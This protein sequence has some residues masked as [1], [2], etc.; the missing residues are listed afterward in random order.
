MAVL[1]IRNNILSAQPVVTHLNPVIEKL[2]QGKHVFGVSTTDLSIANAHALARAD[3]DYVRVEMEHAPMDFGALH[4]FLIGMIDK[5][6]ILKKGNAQLNAAPFIRIAPYGR[7]QAD[8][9][10][11]QALDLGI[12]GIIFPTIETREQALSAVR[13]MRYPQLKGSRYME[14]AGLRGVGPDNAA[15]FWGVDTDEYTR[16][17]D[18]WPLNPQ[19]DLLSIIMIETV[20]GLKNIDEIVSVPGVGGVFAGILGDMPRSLGVE[21]N[22]PEV[23]AARRSILRACLAHNVPCWAPTNAQEVQG[24]IKEGWKYLDLGRAGGGLTPAIDAALRA[25]RAAGR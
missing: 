2:A 19:G 16:R 24:R 4:A 12:M 6:A 7:D 17:A 13:N 21:P 22:S 8:W 1:I 25:G 14:P 3:V 11:K 20:D 9:V 10:V 18:V 15:W 5:A 23:E